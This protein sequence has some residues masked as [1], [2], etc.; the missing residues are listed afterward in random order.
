M[1]VEYSDISG[2]QNTQKVN[3]VVFKMNGNIEL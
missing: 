2:H 3:D 1:Y